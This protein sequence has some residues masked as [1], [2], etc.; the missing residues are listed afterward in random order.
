[1]QIDLQILRFDP[2]RDERPHWDAY[3]VD[4]LSGERVIVGSFGPQRIPD[5]EQRV[6]A[7]PEAAFIERMPCSSQFR[8]AQWCIQVPVGRPE[9]AVR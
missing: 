8:V 6:D 7:H 3:V 5:Y 2:E 9:G 1:M 4:F